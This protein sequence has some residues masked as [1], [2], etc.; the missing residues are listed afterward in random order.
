LGFRDSADLD[1]NNGNTWIL[2]LDMIKDDADN[3]IED[4]DVWI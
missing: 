2:I 3:T 1:Q 4:T